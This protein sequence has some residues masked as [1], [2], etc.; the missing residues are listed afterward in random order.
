M[1]SYDRFA[2]Y[3]IEQSALSPTLSLDCI[4]VGNFGNPAAIRQDSTIGCFLTDAQSFWTVDAYQK[5]Q[6]PR[7]PS[8]RTPPGPI[9]HHPPGGWRPA[10]PSYGGSHP[11]KTFAG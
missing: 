10:Q 2:P 11:P 5:R 8:T 4:G 6:P 9:Q 7:S 3:A 1:L